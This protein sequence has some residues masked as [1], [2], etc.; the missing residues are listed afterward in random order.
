MSPPFGGCVKKNSARL[1]IGNI[2]PKD[3][4]MRL[5]YL[6]LKNYPPLNDIAISFSAESPLKK[7]CAIRFVVGV[8]GSGKTHL[9]QAVLE[10]FLSLAR[11]QKPNF[12]VTLIYE[13]GKGKRCRTVIFDHPGDQEKIGWWQSGFEPHILSPDFEVADWQ[14]LITEIRN[15]PKDWKPFIQN[16]NWPGRRVG[17]PR[18]VIAYTTGETVS[19][20]TIFHLEPSVDTSKVDIKSQSLDYDFNQERPFGWTLQKEIEY[21]VRIGTDESKNAVK[22]L[23]T[24]QE[25]LITQFTDQEVCLFISPLLLKFALLAVTLP[26]AMEDLR[27]YETDKAKQSFFNSLKEEPE[28]EPGLRR[29]LNQVGWV[30][31]VC[32]SFLIDFKPDEWSRMESELKRSLLQAMLSFASETIREPEPGKRR[33]L[34]FDLKAKNSADFAKS[35]SDNAMINQ[36]GS[37]DAFEYVGDALLSFL[38]GKN[39]QPYD[40]F[41]QLLSLYQQSIIQDIRIAIKTNHTDDILMFDELSD[42]EQVFLGRMALFY[43]MQG[44]DDA[45]ILLDEPESHFNDIW[46]REI[47]SIIDEVLG[48]QANEVMISTHS[49]ISLTDVFDDEIQLLKKQDGQAYVSRITSSTFGA[50]PSEIMINIFGAEDSIGKR[51]LKWL[52]DQIDK[53]WTPQQKQELENIIRQ[54]GPGLHR[55]ELRSIWR[56]LNAAQD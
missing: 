5:R 2:W 3:S 25:N 6:S 19:W 34:F 18:T 32:V 43:L 41:K 38:G 27:K 22:E 37:P 26:M 45:L 9:L 21:Q 48:E 29:L 55:S 10:T 35:L 4:H 46:K 1:M 54:I 52:E 40:H 8:N 51:S 28:K 50:D 24:L 20:D 30:W 31:P 44:R 39:G 36:F 17:L 14:N 42:G 33:H 53:E 16:G 7:E 47:V 56:K 12:P 49:S 23:K 15:N 11:Q 13:L